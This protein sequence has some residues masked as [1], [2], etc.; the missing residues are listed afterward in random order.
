MQACS[1][2]RRQTDSFVNAMCLIHVWNKNSMPTPPKCFDATLSTLNPKIFFRNKEATHH[3]PLFAR[4]KIS[5]QRLVPPCWWRAAA[6]SRL[7]QAH[8]GTFKT[9]FFSSTHY[10]PL[11]TG[12]M[13]PGLSSAMSTPRVG[14]HGRDGATPIGAIQNMNAVNIEVNVRRST[15]QSDG[16]PF[17]SQPSKR[18]KDNIQ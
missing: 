1:V 5:R 4:R 2:R 9:V 16:M 7:V 17:A 10:L 11:L 3:A 15:H 12:R 14:Y 8:G 6:L 13:T 18:T